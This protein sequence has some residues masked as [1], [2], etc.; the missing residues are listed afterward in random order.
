MPLYIPPTVFEKKKKTKK[1]KEKVGHFVL[2][3]AHLD[4]TS[5]EANEISIDIYDSAPGEV[6]TASITKKAR[7]VVRRSGW[8]GSP[9]DVPRMKPECSQGDWPLVPYQPGPYLRVS[10]YSQR[11]GS[12]AWDP[13]SAGRRAP[14]AALF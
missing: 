3:V 10:C 8:L 12:H 11:K 6:N 1:G 2:G 4:P 5:K 14:R 13:N 9:L 7:E